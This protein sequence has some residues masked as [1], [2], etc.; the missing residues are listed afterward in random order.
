MRYKELARKTFAAGIG[1]QLPVVQKLLASFYV[2]L[3][4]ALTEE[5]EKIRGQRAGR[6]QTRVRALLGLAR[7][8]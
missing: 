6:R 1:A 5:Q 4:E 3:V 2:P 7:T 8:G